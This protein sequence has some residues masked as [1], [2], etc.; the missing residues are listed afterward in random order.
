MK[1]YLIIVILGIIFTLPSKSLADSLDQICSSPLENGRAVPIRL[2]LHGQL[3]IPTLNH[4]SKVAIFA[5]STSGTSAKVKLK[6]QKAWWGYN[7]PSYEQTILVNNSESWYEANFHEVPVNPGASYFLTAE[8][9][10]NASIEWY[11]KD[12]A[13]CNPNGYAFVGGS[14]ERDKDFYFWTRGYNE[15]IQLGDPAAPVEQDQSTDPSAVDNSIDNSNSSN[16]APS[17]GTATP[18]S[19]TNETSSEIPNTK[20]S[21]NSTSKVGSV[22]TKEVSIANK[23]VSGAQKISDEEVEQVLKMIAEDYAKQKRGIFGI[24]GV[25]GRI[26]TWPILVGLAAAL[27]LFIGFIFTMIAIIKRSNRRKKP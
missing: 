5:K 15:T 6:I 19:A 3:F 23:S 24:G 13:D 10:N 27:I 7:L 26:L 22:S 25:V 17:I 1:K 4:I 8:P 14:I 20:P 21:T 18:S 2:T 16:P 9:I 12:E 11:V